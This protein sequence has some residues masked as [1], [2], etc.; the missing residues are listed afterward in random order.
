[1]PREVHG[2]VAAQVEAAQE[3]ILDVVSQM[4]QSDQELANI[5]VGAEHIIITRSDLI[6]V[7]QTLAAHRREQGFAT[8][9][10][11]VEDIYD[12]HAGGQPSPWAIR[13][14]IRDAANRWEV[15]PRYIVL[16]GAS[17]GDDGAGRSR[18][19]VRGHGA[20]KVPIMFPRNMG[21]AGGNC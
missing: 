5:Q 6:G 9:V 16:A 13:D 2:Q 19:Q 14:F 7:A 4:A 10:V 20:Q 18:G 8:L 11:D 12:A 3:V 21:E 15:Q 17:H 1:M